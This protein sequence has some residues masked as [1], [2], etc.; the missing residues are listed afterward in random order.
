MLSFTGAMFRTINR[1]LTV[2]NGETS[3][4]VPISYH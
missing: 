1:N 4:K 3:E 2:Q